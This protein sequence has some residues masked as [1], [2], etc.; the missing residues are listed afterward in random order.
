VFTSSTIDLRKFELEELTRRVGSQAGR[1]DEG[2]R[3]RHFHLATAHEEKT[4]VLTSVSATG[5]QRPCNA[6][7]SIQADESLS[8]PL[9]QPT[10][11]AQV[12]SDSGGHRKAQGHLKQR[13]RADTAKPG[14]QRVVMRLR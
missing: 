4:H 6:S 7:T 10:S 12:T 3:A 14:L 11:L 5:P 9:S 1:A 13:A 2:R 8:N